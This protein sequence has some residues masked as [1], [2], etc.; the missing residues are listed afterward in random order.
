MAAQD[1]GR[2]EAVGHR[3]VPIPGAVDT[4]DLRAQAPAGQFTAPMLRLREGRLPEASEV[5]MTDGAARD[6]GLALGGTVTIGAEKVSVVGIVENP[7][8]LGDEFLLG[9]SSTLARSTSVTIFIARPSENLAGQLRSGARYTIEGRGNDENRIAAA[10]VFLLAVIV[11]L[12]VALVAAAGFAVVAQRRLRQL[13]ML[14]S[15]GAT[16]RQVRLVMVAHGLLVGTAAAILGTAVAVAGWVWACPRLEN[17]VGHRMDRLAI[18]IWLL[19]AGPALAIITAVGA[20]WWPARAVARIPVMSALSG[21]PPPPK[22]TSRSAWAAAALVG[23]GFVGLAVAIDVKTGDANVWLLIISTVSLV[24]GVLFVSPI[25]VRAAASTAARLPLAPRLALRELGRYQARS[26]AALAAITLSLGIAVTTIV[27]ASAAEPDSGEGDLPP[28]QMLVQAEA[29][30]FGNNIPDEAS[31]SGV[32]EIAASL[33]HPS[34]IELRTATHATG[35]PTIDGRVIQ[36]PVILARRIN[37]NSFR[38]ECILYVATPELLAPYGIDVSSLS[39]DVDVLT[40]EA[41]ALQYAAPDRAL[42]APNVQRISGPRYSESPHCFITAAAVQ[43]GGFGTTLHGWL[44]TADRPLGPDEI[45]AAR[46]AAARSGLAVATR[47]SGGPVAT[48]RR[49]A[50]AAGSLVALCILAM[51]IGLIR[52]EAGRDLRTLTATGATSLV[53]RTLTAA[54]S[55]ALAFLGAALAIVGAYVAMIACYLD[56]LGEL[57]AVPIVDLAVILFGLPL[58]AAAASW[59]LSG[60]EPPHLSTRPM[61]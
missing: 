45:R 3:R 36:P 5:A 6:L 54:T 22:R 27:I 37:E 28:D 35:K 52:S 19:I 23:A 2:V 9:H 59:L 41:G 60:R 21:R 55:G 48:T 61:D 13:G 33:D 26:G 39:S 40:T 34:V 16:D 10:L 51:T 24:T 30:D 14:A 17:G 31:R 53:R 50:T 15:I 38:F 43:R 44:M 18:P 1:F 49:V 56:D 29:D 46:A 4:V 57:S 11:L 42:P 25:A 8:D 58:A 12:L 20:A 32:T 47:T 7:A